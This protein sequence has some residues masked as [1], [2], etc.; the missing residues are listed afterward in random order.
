V[1]TAKGTG[2]NYSVAT[3]I[4]IDSVV[5]V[6]M[7]QVAIFRDNNIDVYKFAEVVDRLSYYYQNAY[8][9]VENNSEGSA[10]INR[11]WWDLEN[12]NLVNSGSKAINLGIRASRT[13]KPKAVLLMKKIIEDGSLRIPDKETVEELS[14]YIEENDKFFGKDKPDDTVSAL[15]W[16]LYILEMN[17]L[18]EKY[19]F[20]EKEEANDI[21]GVL[22]DIVK[23]TEDWN[24]LYD[25]N[26]YD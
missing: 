7:E 19:E 21:W 5:P 9:M 15:Y 23:D 11:L 22:S 17:I 2:E 8:I 26:V 12:E 10:I 4:K 14:T 25:S 18:D 3:V 20:Q 16:A 1:D 24:W 13:T 6:K